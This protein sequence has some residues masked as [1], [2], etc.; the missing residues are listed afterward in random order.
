[1]LSDIVQRWRS[2]WSADELARRL[3]RWSVAELVGLPLEVV[4]PFDTQF[5]D[6]ESARYYKSSPVEFQE[7][8]GDSLCVM[9]WNI[10]FGGGRIDFWYDGHGDRVMLEAWEVLQNLEGLADKIRGVDPDVLLVQEVDVDSRRVAHIDQMQWLLDHT[11]L[12]FGAYASQWQ[13]RYVPSQ[14][15]GK[16]DMGIGVLSKYPVGDAQRLAL[17][18][19][20]SVDRVTRYFYLKRAMLTARLEIPGFDDVHVVNIHAEAFSRDGT[21]KRQLQC[22]KSELDRID[23][24]GGLVV[25][26][27]DL[28][29]LPP[30][31]EKCHGFADIADDIAETFEGGGDYRGQEDWLMPLYQRY[32]S[33]IP[34]DDYR[35]DNEPYGTHSSTRD[36]FWCRKLDY[37]FSNGNFVDGAAMTHQDRSTGGVETMALSDHAPVSASLALEH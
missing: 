25:G 6:V 16:V 3:D 36:V 14:R 34:L 11:D 20:T 7:P 5:D 29:T 26:G 19:M 37:L 28:N 24:A 4:D 8:D 17:P 9:T 1:M 15:L 35:R 31:T 32:R 30:G 21:K 2:R 18:L 13:S 33:A 23:D 12:N 10:K 22:F 27:G